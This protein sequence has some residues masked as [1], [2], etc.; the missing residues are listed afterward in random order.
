MIK[1]LFEKQ[2]ALMIT[3]LGLIVLF[4]VLMAASLFDTAEISGVNRWV[5]PMKF[6]VSIALYLLTLAIYLYFISGRE[7]AKISLVGA[8]LR[9]WSAKSF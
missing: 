6:A 5:K 3:G 4:V 9:R 2:R 8:R 7:P 1:E